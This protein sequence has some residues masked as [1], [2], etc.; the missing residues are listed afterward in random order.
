MHACPCYDTCMTN[1]VCPACM[2]AV[3]AICPWATVVVY[4]MRRTG[5]PATE[6]ATTSRCNALTSTLGS[7]DGCLVDIFT[8]NT[9]QSL[10]EC[11]CDRSKACVRVS[12]TS[13][14]LLTV[15]LANALGR[16]NSTLLLALRYTCQT[17]RWPKPGPGLS[18][19]HTDP[20]TITDPML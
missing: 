18:C 5:V 9:G 8:H 6:S 3:S 1:A 4:N 15:T 13:R 10:T 11:P 20:A 2:H 16:P 19:T 7:S 17:Q 14:I 12:V